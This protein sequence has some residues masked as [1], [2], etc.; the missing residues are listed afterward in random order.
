MAKAGQIGTS[1]GSKFVWVKRG[2]TLTRD[3]SKAAVSAAKGG[4]KSPESVGGN[5][6]INVK[7]KSN[8]GSSAPRTSTRPP[9]NPR[10]NSSAAPTSSARPKARPTTTK[11][12][13][14]TK[15]TGVGNYSSANSAAPRTSVRPKLRPSA[16]TKTRTVKSGER[17]KTTTRR[18]VKSG[19]RGQSSIVKKNHTYDEVPA[20]R[21][22]TT[23]SSSTTKRRLAST[24]K[25]GPKANSR[26]LTAT[27]RA[28]AAGKRAE[29]ARK[30]VEAA[31]KRAEARKKTEVAANKRKRDAEA[32]RSSNRRADSL[33][34]SKVKVKTSVTRKVTQKQ[35]DDEANRTVNRRKESLKSGYANRSSSIPRN[36]DARFPG[37]RRFE[38]LAKAAVDQNDKAYESWSNRLSKLK[39]QYSKWKK[40]RWKD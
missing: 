35:K 13:S 36:I 12:T 21:K 16:T 15:A 9:T 8:G 3:F 34:P 25:G 26:T 29:E 30:K 24:A 22:A 19:E 39:S 14:T 40:G 11:P 27:A 5:S 32:N 6:R 7:P 4:T 37:A 31:R 18:T 10:R 23:T 20:A 2:N 38:A 28:E 17:G 1:D 33:K